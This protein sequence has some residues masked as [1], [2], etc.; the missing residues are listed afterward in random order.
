MKHVWHSLAEPA[1]VVD[2]PV[3]LQTLHVDLFWLHDLEVPLDLQGL[4]A[5]LP[6]GQPDAWRPSASQVSLAYSH[7]CVPTGAVCA[8]EVETAWHR[9]AVDLVS[10]LWSPCRRLQ[11]RQHALAGH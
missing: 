8:V 10:S 5:C 2:R 9:V 11:R 6:I 7:G 3:I 4:A 1:D